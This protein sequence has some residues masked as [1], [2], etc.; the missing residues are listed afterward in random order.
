ML[1]ATAKP[2]ATASPILS[3]VNEPGPE[4]TAKTS[5]E[6]MLVLVKSSKD[7]II[8]IKVLLCTIVVFVV[9]CPKVFS[10]SCNATEVVLVAVSMPNIFI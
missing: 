1:P 4:E 9:I 6:L 8:G 5:I 2:F 3:P 7:I 10:S